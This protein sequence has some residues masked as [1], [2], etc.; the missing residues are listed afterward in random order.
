[1]RQESIGLL[2][3][4]LSEIEA[5]RG[6]SGELAKVPNP[7]WRRDFWFR[8][9]A[10]VILHGSTEPDA[11]VTIAGRPVALRP[12]GSFSFRF[13]FPDGN[14]WLPIEAVSADGLDGRKAA[15]RFLRATTLE[16]DVGVHPVSPA[17][18]GAL[19]EWGA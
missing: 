15:V 1:V 11:R 5:C 10:E 7:A 2:P 16:G 6:S 4:G 13:A 17:W 18:D 14:F 3:L 9:N 12:D 8:V 19:E